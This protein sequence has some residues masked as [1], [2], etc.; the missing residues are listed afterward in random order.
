MMQA[1][2]YLMIS[3]AA[4]TVI[5]FWGRA[6]ARRAV[7]PTSM[8]V[9]GAIVAGCVAIGLTLVLHRPVDLAPYVRW[10]TL[11]LAALMAVTGVSGTVFYFEALGRGPAG[12]VATVCGLWMIVPTIVALWMWDDGLSIANSVGL[13]VGLGAIACMSAPPRSVE[14]PPAVSPFTTARGLTWRLF[15]LSAMLLIGF[16]AV[17]AKYKQVHHPDMPDV[18]LLAMYWVLS[19]ALLG[20]WQALRRRPIDAGAW[21]FG[22]A[23]GVLMLLTNLSLPAIREFRATLVFLVCSALPP[24]L[25]VIISMI[26]LRERYPLRVRLAVGLGLASLILMVI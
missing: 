3:V 4:S 12:P 24:A 7:D 2:F 20:S 15:A 14:T 1:C 11:T 23:M 10:P 19:A 13:L 17:V 9:A 18:L 26:V 8:V 16:N 5:V 22:A 25:V 21:R 6:A